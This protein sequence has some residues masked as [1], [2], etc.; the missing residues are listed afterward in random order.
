MEALWRTHTGTGSGSD[1]KSVNQLKAH[2]P[3][4]SKNKDRGN[5]F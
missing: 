5:D 2:L 3:W 1:E 4:N